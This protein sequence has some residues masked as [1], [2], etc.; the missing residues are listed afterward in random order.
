MLARMGRISGDR[1]EEFIHALW[2][3]Q[4]AKDDQKRIDKNDDSGH[5]FYPPEEREQL[6]KRYREARAA[7]KVFRKASWVE[8]N[9]G[10]SVRT[11][12]NWEEEFPEE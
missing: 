7:G 11:F 4:I 12:Q 3:G 10:V 1:M 9:I 2:Y 5:Y 8:D 6:V